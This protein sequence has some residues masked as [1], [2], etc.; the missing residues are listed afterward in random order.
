MKKIICILTTTLVLVF[1]AFSLM[2]CSKTSIEGVFQYQEGSY[3]YLLYLYNDGSGYNLTIKNDNIIHSTH[4]NYQV[5]EE[6]KYLAINSVDGSD[7]EIVKYELIDKNH[8][9]IDGM[10]FT[11]K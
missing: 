2:G 11:R 1:S 4:Y 10:T 3:T 6:N 8:I 5:L 9:V 7:T